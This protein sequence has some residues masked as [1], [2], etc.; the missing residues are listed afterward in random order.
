M[1]TLTDKLSELRS[2]AAAGGEEAL[3]AAVAAR[4]EAQARAAAL[5]RER[6]RIQGE[7]D[8]MAAALA[9]LQRDVSAGSG[10][11]VTK[12]TLGISF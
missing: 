3:Q 2:K 4:D 10:G 11:K 9:R 6:G 1:E 12:H 5:S 8:D 7:V